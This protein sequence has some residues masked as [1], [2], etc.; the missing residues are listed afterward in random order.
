MSTNYSNYVDLLNKIEN[1]INK[2]ISRGISDKLFNQTKLQFI[3]LYKEGLD[4]PKGI[5]N[6]LIDY[7]N[8]KLESLEEEMEIINSITIDDIIENTTTWS[9]DTIYHLN[10]GGHI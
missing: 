1:E 6:K 4:N 5:L 7:K 10:N 8:F 2:L 3:N 9:I